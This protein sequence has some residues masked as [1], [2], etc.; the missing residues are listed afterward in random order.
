MPDINTIAFSW[1]EFKPQHGLKTR[2]TY[3]AA[4]AVTRLYTFVVNLETLEG[5][6]YESYNQKGEKG[7][8]FVFT[9]TFYIYI[10]NASPEHLEYELR[11]HDCGWFSC[12]I[13]PCQK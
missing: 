5:G 6:Y 9:Q 8:L 3:E 10:V 11:R 1:D 7:E 4:N 2:P 13:L 12:R